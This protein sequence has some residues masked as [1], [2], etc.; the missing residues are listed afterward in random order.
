MKVSNFFYDICV[1][2]RFNLLN[3]IVGEIFVSI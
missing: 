3:I 1:I 2:I